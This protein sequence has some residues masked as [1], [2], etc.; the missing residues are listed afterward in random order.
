M[1]IPHLFRGGSFLAACFIAITVFALSSAVASADT[2]VLKNG[3]RLTG[4]IESSD[5]KEIIFKTAYAGEIKV[6]WSAVKETTTDKPVVLTTTDKSTLSGTESSEESNI[7]VHTSNAGDVTVP[8]TNVTIVRSADAQQ[9]YEKSL[10]PGWLE[11]WKG[12]ANFGFALAR[13]NSDTTNLSVGFNADRKTTNDETKTYFTSI[14]ATTG[15]PVS[16]TTANELMGGIRFDRNINHILFGFV[17][18]DFAHNALQDLDLQQIYSGGLGAHFINTPNT[19]LDVLAG[20][21]YTRESY[22]GVPSTGGP[23]VS[24][25]RNLGAI[26]VGEDFV[27]K[28]GTTSNFNEHFYFY[29]DLSDTGQYRF[30]L[31]AA[32]VTQIKK[33]LGWQITVSDRYITN[34][35]IAGTKDNDVVLSTGIN[36]A[37]AH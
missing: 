13:G 16:A 33:W 25:Q 32:W 6:Q 27:K 35:P 37:F 15:T 5:A 12:G 8:L 11:D 29:P 31:D 7:V 24:V 28:F 34:P 14:Y 9:A 17:G 3:D 36:V 19:T 30:A 26:T 20:G 21:N 1:L 10:H 18:G 23:S 2:I 22:S 4:T